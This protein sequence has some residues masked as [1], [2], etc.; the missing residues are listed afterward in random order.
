MAG[1]GGNILAGSKWIT[2]WSAA[3]QE[4]WPD[5]STGS[6][7]TTCSR[8]SP[9]LTWGTGCVLIPPTGHGTPP[10]HTYTSP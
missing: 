2:S 6:E 8:A 1:L 3:P 7:E 4:G 5:Q 10:P 9:Q